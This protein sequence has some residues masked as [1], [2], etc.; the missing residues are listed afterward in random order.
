MNL[1]ELR[2]TVTKSSFVAVSHSIKA[3]KKGY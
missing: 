3:K 2:G 1:K